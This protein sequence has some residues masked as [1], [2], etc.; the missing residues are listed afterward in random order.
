M[1][2]PRRYPDLRQET[3]GPQPRAEPR[4]QHL[5][6]D[7]SLVLEVD[8]E[9][10]TCHTTAPELTL[11]AVLP[12]DRIREGPDV[13]QVRLMGRQHHRPISPSS[14]TPNASAASASASKRDARLI[15]TVRQK[16]PFV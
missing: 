14:L 6:R 4:V 12:R 3:F 1:L 15:S 8:R 5:A 9:I 11:D 2:Q 7:S 16:T 13:A 10:D